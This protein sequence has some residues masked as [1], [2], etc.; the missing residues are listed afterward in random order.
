MLHAIWGTSSSARIAISVSSLSS[1]AVACLGQRVR[2]KSALKN[3]DTGS[4]S[5]VPSRDFT[6]AM[7]L[8][9]A[10]LLDAFATSARVVTTGADFSNHPFA[11]SMMK[12]FMALNKA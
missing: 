4:A 9:G 8:P 7:H 12:A 10:S 2:I 1:C 6:N 11:W 3:L 5:V